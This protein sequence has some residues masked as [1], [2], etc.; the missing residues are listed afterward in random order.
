MRLHISAEDIER[1][2]TE[3]AAS[4]AGITTCRPP[5]VALSPH[6]HVAPVITGRL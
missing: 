4:H 5:Y 1:M 3:F 6:Y 2:V